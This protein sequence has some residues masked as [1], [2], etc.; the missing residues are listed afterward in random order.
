MTAPVLSLPQD[1]LCSIANNLLP[2]H[3][4]N[5]RIFHYSYDWLN[6]LNSSKEDFGKW[7]KESQIIVLT[8]SDARRFRDLKEFREKVYQCIEN[9]HFQLDVVL[10][11]WEDNRLVDL[12]L[13]DNVR[14]IHLKDCDCVAPPTMDVN[15]M[16]LL[17]CQIE[18]FS[19][20]SNVKSVTVVQVLDPLQRILDL[21]LF[22]K[23]E[24]GCFRLN[25][26]SSTNHHL[27]SNLKS[28][29]LQCCRSITDVSCFQNIPHLS[30][31]WCHAITDVSSL[32]K[33]HTLNLMGCLNIRDVSALGR[34]HTLD[35]SY[36]DQVTDLSALEWV[37]CLTFGRF[38][39]TDLS[40]LKNIVVLNIPDASSVT[41][42][43]MLH[44][45]Q[46]LNIEECDGICS[47]KG[48]PKLKELW[49]HESD[50][51]RI[52]SGNE[53]FPRLVTLN[54]VGFESSPS[55]LLSSSLDR[56]QDLTLVGYIW[57]DSSCISF[58]PGLRS[59]TISCCKGFT[60]LPRLPP[61]LGYLK[62]YGCGLHSLSIPRK[63]D[64]NSS[65]FPLYHLI[66]DDCRLLKRLHMYEKVFK[67]RISRCSQLTTIV[68]NE[69]IGH[70][71]IRNVD[72]LEKI[73]NWSKIVC[74]ALFVNPEKVLNVDPEKNELRVG[75]W[76]APEEN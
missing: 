51:V 45:L 14:K 44:S 28:L 54:V 15:E 20:C 47:L 11:K 9:P 61:S 50:R 35:L 74:P 6:F 63:D 30:L 41:D 40:G 13:F 53:V 23:I 33:V 2:L 59:L 12:Q 19:F 26:M 29:E 21:S 48:L 10:E 64:E 57:N 3:E 36:C 34:V 17:Q 24:K 67:C 43:T 49:M 66:I 4:Q 16:F 52:T 60:V 70:L 38:Q 71:R 18:D 55:S 32:G 42:I 68:V 1:I 76:E 65:S 75:L 5:K 62:I 27:L 7:K 22:Q 46:V 39:G 69:Q 58:F 8:D 31:T 72:S 56:V 25:T 73:V 37:Y